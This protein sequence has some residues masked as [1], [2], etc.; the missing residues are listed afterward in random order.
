MEAA[1]RIAL[2]LLGLGIGDAFAEEPGLDE[3]RDSPIFVVRA[4]P[5][6]PMPPSDRTFVQ[7]QLTTLLRSEIGL[8]TVPALDATGSE[9][10][11]EAAGHG[12]MLRLEK[13]TVR[14][15]RL[16]PP[17]MREST[18]EKFTRTGYLWEFT[19]TKRFM[20]GPKGDKVGVMFSFDW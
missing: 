5:P 3:D 2:L 8:A 9:P 10:E 16:P 4:S 20:I 15:P 1:K 14:A 6:A 13:M 12:Q 19:P 17:A 18:F 11:G 7:Q